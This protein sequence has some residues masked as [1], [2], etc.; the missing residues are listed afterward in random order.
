MAALTVWWLANVLDL[1]EDVPETNGKP[2]KIHE[3]GHFWTN[4]DTMS[5]F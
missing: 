2:P 5:R 1:L 3:M 4:Q